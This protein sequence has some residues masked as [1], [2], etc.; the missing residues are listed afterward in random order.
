MFGAAEEHTVGGA[1]RVTVGG[2]LIGRG[3]PLVLIAGPCV[4]ES[5]EVVLETAEALLRIVGDVGLPLVFKSSYDKANRSS[6]SS[7]RG[8]GLSRGLSILQG[9]KERFGIPVLS[10]IHSVAEAGP[11]AEVLDVL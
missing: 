4:I 7:F 3:L 11:A 8:P 1:R 2:I 10:D 9:V 5:E 6:A